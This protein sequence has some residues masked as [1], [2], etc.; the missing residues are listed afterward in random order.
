MLMS[1]P[2]TKGELSACWAAGFGGHG[3]HMGNI[4][5]AARLPDLEN[6]SFEKESE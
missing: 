3:A 1:V 5:T 4:T 2:G 6:V